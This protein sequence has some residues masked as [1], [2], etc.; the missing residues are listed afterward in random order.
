MGKHHRRFKPGGPRK[1]YTSTERTRM[2]NVHNADVFKFHLTEIMGD[3]KMS[4]EQKPT[5]IANVL[6]K[7]S[8]NSIVDAQDYVDGMQK[9]G[10]V[11]PQVA[12]QIMRL[13]DHYSTRR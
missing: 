13:L 2:L 12:E 7:A 9:D 4:T 1:Q 8:R 3:S 5:F 11:E 10:L 6:L